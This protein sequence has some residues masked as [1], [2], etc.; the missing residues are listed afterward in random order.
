MKRKATKKKPR[1]AWECV[2]HYV[3]SKGY[4]YWLS[5]LINE[6]ILHEPWL[7]ESVDAEPWI[8]RTDCK[9][10]P[11]FLTVWGWCPQPLHCSRAHYTQ[12]R[13]T[14]SPSLVLCSLCQPL[15]VTSFIVFWF[16]L[17]L[18]HFAKITHLSLFPS[19]LHFAPCLS[20]LGNMFWKSLISSQQSFSFFLQLHSAPLCGCTIVSFPNLCLDI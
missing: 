18:F 10:T 12:R 13:V 20:S 19:F 17:P 9:V 1:F 16:I 6:H 4:L 15:Q 2:S 11:S 7:I 5:S 3:D 8:Q 14:S